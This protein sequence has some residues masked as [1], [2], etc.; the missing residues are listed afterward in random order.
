[1]GDSGRL[2]RDSLDIFEK[3]LEEVLDVEENEKEER[4]GQGNRAEEMDNV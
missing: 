3:N 2:T 4:R 1:M